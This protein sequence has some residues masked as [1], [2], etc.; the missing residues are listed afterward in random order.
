MQKLEPPDTHYLRAAEGW[1]ELGLH[2]EAAAE[3]DG[4]SPAHQRHPDVLEL[5][6]ALD[7]QRARWDAALDAARKLVSIAPSRVSGWLHQSF[8]MRRVDK[9][10]VAKAMEALMPA[11]EKFPKDPT[12]SYNLSCYACQLRKYDEARFWLRRAFQIGNKEHVKRIALADPDLKPL[13][14]EIRQLG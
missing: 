12:V 3:L 9:G 6:C 8:A 14:E 11:A 5:R 7:I 4:I 1:H 2:A 10:G 13:W